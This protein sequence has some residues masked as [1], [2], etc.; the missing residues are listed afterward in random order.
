MPNYDAFISYS[1]AADS[2]LAPAL[3]RALQRFAKPWWKL[4]AL[5]LFRGEASRMK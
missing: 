5:N 3:Q 4:R 1:H 2:R